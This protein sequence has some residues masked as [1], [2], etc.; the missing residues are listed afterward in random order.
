[1]KYLIR[2]FLLTLVGL[3]NTNAHAVPQSLDRIV[4][5]VNDEVITESQLTKKIQF[6]QQQLQSSGQPVPPEAT[7]RNQILQQMIDTDLQQQVAKRMGV[8]VTD[9]DVNNAIADIAKRNGVDVTIFQEKLKQQGVSLVV[10]RQQIR[11]QITLSQVEGRQLGS[12]IIISEQEVKSYA[13]K[14]KSQPAKSN[15]NAQYR[16]EDITIALP[17]HPTAQDIAQ[18]KQKAHTIIEKARTGKSFQDIVQSTPASESVSGTDLGWRP[19]NAVPDVFIKDVQNMRAGEISKPLQAPNGIHVIKLVAVQGD[20][21]SVPHDAVSTH[22]R[23]ILLKTTPLTNDKQMR[24]RLLEIR[25][26]ILRGG[27]FAK[28]AGEYSQD[29][30]SAAKGGDL[31]WMQSGVLDPQFEA[32]MNQLKPGQVSEPV[33]SQFG[34]HLIEVIARKTEKND[35]AALENQAREM[36]YQQKMHEAVQNWIQQLRK[37]SFI[38]IT[39]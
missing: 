1:M 30:G 28:L 9:A 19:I 32:A 20:T 27:D 7:F 17:E 18:A 36:L 14:L 8:K 22:V 3:I 25:A 26:D 16:L 11:D 2:V 5:V 31:G 15:T 6:M 24:M 10:L 39:P 12:R 37:Q 23:H 29:P 33:K 38:K 4:A 35:Q 13:Q 21:A 34:W